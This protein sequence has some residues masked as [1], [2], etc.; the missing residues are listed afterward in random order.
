VRSAGVVGVTGHPASYFNRRSL[1]DYAEAWRIGR[2]RDGKVDET[3]VRAARTAGRTANGVF[4]GRVMAETLP[5]LIAGL[6]APSR[7]AVTDLELAA[8]PTGTAHRVLDHLG[9]DV[10]PDRQL[11]VGQHRQADQLNAE[12]ITTFTSR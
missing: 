1:D 6:A 10:P 3:F 9:L 11:V 8:D 4:G 2:P 12:W 7:L 5:E